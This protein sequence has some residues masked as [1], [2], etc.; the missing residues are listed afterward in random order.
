MTTQRA[1]LAVVL[2]ISALVAGRL[3][4]QGYRVRLD[5]RGQSVSYQGV[6]VDSIPIAQVVT[7]PDGSLYSPD[8]YA[9]KCSNL[10]Y[11]FFYRAGP[12]LHS[13][14]LSTTA[15]LVLWGFGLKGLS[16]HASGRYLTDAGSGS[17]WPGTEPNAQLLE[18][19]LEYG[20][21]WLLV[22]GGRQYQ[23]SRLL[24]IGYDGA[25][26]RGRWD[27]TSLELTGYGGWGLGQA[28]VVPVTSPVLTPLDDWRPVKRQILAGGELAWMPGPVDLRAE[29]R[30]EVDPELNY[31][32]SERASLSLNARPAR[33]FRVTGGADWN[34][35]EGQVGSAD[36]TVTYLGSRLTASAGG[37]RYKPYF[38]LWT[39]WG[40]FS[41]VPY[42]GFNASAQYKA[43]NWLS[44]RT[45]GER[46]QYEA[47]EASS[48]L[49]QTVDNGWRWSIGGTVTPN[50][51]WT[52]DGAYLLEDGPGASSRYFDGSVTYQPSERI[53]VAA[54]GG[55]LYRP[56]ELRYYDATGNW[57]GGRAAWG[58]A[59]QMRIWA[60]AQY[61]MDKRDRP[62]A[63]K[64]DWNQV[65]LRG[66]ITV[67]FGSNA[68]R[69]APLPPA[70][71]SVP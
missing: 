28:A 64:T 3:E 42:N 23:S 47:A 49:V 45:R 55:R 33:Q 14:P 53:Q 24:P 38:N 51:K 52:L 20:S 44:L 26:A 60:D 30:R 68:D 36:L 21:G 66:G 65:R 50:S 56:L 17:T 22:R 13:V 61:F 35:D 12:L 29:Y 46:Y 39:L 15:D 54:Y 25:W 58:F 41:P 69:R 40:A 19:Y 59:N 70:R 18:G 11:C 7:K 34:M 1:A 8:G 37:K 5:A 4:A 6:A 10:S 63:A 31:L 27:R 62:D 48:A 43:T 32:V 2:A 9:V 57:F 67:T 16:L 71:R